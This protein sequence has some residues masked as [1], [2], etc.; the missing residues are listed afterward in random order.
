MHQQIDSYFILFSLI[1]HQGEASKVPFSQLKSI[2][3]ELNIRQNVLEYSDK[4]Q[5]DPNSLNCTPERFAQITCGDLG[6]PPDME[7]SI[8]F[9]IRETIVKYTNTHI[10]SNQC[11]LGNCFAS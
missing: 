9:D 8:A 7:P 10:L 3:I 1:H 6:L 4:F 5:W 11:W 2:V